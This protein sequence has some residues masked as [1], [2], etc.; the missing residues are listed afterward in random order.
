MLYPFNMLPFKNVWRTR[1]SESL[2]GNYSQN[3]FTTQKHYTD[4]SR[5]TI[6]L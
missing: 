2:Q 1:E 4:F 6:A 5:A 3:F